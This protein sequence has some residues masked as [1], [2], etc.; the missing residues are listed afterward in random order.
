[1]G[2]ARHELEYGWQ[3]LPGHLNQALTKILISKGEEDGAGNAAQM[4]FMQ[5][6]YEPGGYVELHAHEKTEEIFYIISG[7][8]RAQ[9]GEELVNLE[10]GSFMWVPPHTA[11]GITNTG[12]EPLK[13]LI[14]AYPQYYTDWNDHKIADGAPAVK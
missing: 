11:H 14:I 4:Q 8:G 1:M 6:S 2:L 9:V 10:P 12:T 3:N 13:F 7:R 5:S